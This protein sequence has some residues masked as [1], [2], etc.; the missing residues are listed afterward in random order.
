MTDN[1]QALTAD[2]LADLFM[3]PNRARPEAE[4]WAVREIEN[5]RA[6]NE[7]LR[8]KDTKTRH[9]LKGWVWV[10]PD[11]GDEPTHERVAAVVAEV[12]RLRAE[13]NTLLEERNTLLFDTRRFVRWFNR[14]YPDPTSNPDH[15]WY[16]D[17]PWCAINSR[18]NAHA[19][20]LETF[21]SGVETKEANP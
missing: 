2:E 6:E 14:H 21:D 15:P 18:L 7:R 3:D 9:A 12:E 8:A 16:P 5:L 4:H 11:G 13:R 1:R 19:D 10:C 17:H 20:V